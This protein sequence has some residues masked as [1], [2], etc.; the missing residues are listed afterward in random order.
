MTVSVSAIG[1]HDSTLTATV[2]GTGNSVTPT[3]II[4]VRA[5]TS[6]MFRVTAG[7]DA[8]DE[9]LTLTASHPDYDSA[10]AEVD[11]RVVLRP[12]E[13]SVEPSPLKVVIDKSADIDD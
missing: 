4:G 12:L 8:G 6:A 13:L 10:N 3:E 9:T 7:F 11:V 1:N 2:T 5:G